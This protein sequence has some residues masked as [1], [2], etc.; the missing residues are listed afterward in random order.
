MSS[1]GKA[2]GLLVLIVA[3]LQLPAPANAADDSFIAS[4]TQSAVSLAADGDPAGIGMLRLLLGLDDNYKHLF[5]DLIEQTQMAETLRKSQ[6]SFEPADQARALKLLEQLAEAEG[7][8]SR[9]AA[10]NVSTGTRVVVVDFTGGKTQWL[11]MPREDVEAGELLLRTVECTPELAIF[12]R[13][14][15]LPSMVR[16]GT[17]RYTASLMGLS[18]EDGA[19]IRV[20]P[21]P[22]NAERLTMVLDWRRRRI[23][24]PEIASGEQSVAPNQVT[25]VSLARATRSFTVQTEPGYVYSTYAAP[26]DSHVDPILARM[27]PNSPLGIIDSD[28]DGGWE[29]AAKLQTFLGTGRLEKFTVSRND[30]TQGDVA[31]FVSKQQIPIRAIEAGD[32]VNV[33]PENPGWQMIRVPAGRWTVETGD[34]SSGFDPVLSVFDL[35]TGELVARNDDADEHTM[36]SR[37]HLNLR[38]PTDLA[39][40]VDSA[41]KDSG[42]TRLVLRPDTVSVRARKHTMPPRIPRVGRSVSKL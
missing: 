17:V 36:A 4:F 23:A 12:S 37:V 27:D 29:A 26:V 21:G 1:P 13:N 24:L 33:T 16:S 11:A 14:T 32:P 20:R 34:L 31:V 35:K 42:S 38:D 7:S 3:A 22:C 30:A 19:A 15:A 8:A 41:D 5:S 9:A 25:I 10:Q 6:H 39:M 40:R 18:I 28:D 2:I